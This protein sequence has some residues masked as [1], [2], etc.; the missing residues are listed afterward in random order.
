M[1]F[2][3]SKDYLSY[4]V[5][6]G[7]LAILLGILALFMNKPDLILG[8]GWTIIGI[9]ALYQYYENRKKPYIIL[10]NETL[11]VKKIFGY[12]KYLIN[13]FNEV[14]KKNNSIIL[15]KRNNKKKKIY[16]WPIEKNSQDLFYEEINKII[17]R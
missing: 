7:I 11:L 5:F 13:E 2:Y 17:I 9:I 3:Y 1:K 6:Y 12:K 10:N 4:E 8:F 16:T 14:I 15:K